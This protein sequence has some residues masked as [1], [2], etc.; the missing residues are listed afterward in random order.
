MRVVAH[1]KVSPW[2]GLLPLLKD[3]ELRIVQDFT[4]VEG[5]CI[6]KGTHSTCRGGIIG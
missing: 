3:L 4:G 6:G 2:I 5:D 1:S